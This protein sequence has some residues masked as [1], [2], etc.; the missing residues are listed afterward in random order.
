MTA[1]Q[2]GGRL[3]RLA[4]RPAPD[5]VDGPDVEERCEMCA[6]PL[7]PE[8][9]HLL[10]V[11]HQL[12]VCVCRA[13]ALLFD[14]RESG[15]GHYRRV[16]DRRVRLPELRLDDVQWAGFGIPVDIA[17]FVRSSASKRVVG[18]YPSPLGTMR[19][20]LD[21]ESWD[22]LEAD[23]PVLR[24]MEEDVEALL[25]NR[26]RG[27]RDHWLLPVTDCYRLVAAIRTHWKGIS[28]GHEVWEALSGFFG[29]LPWGPGTSVME[30]HE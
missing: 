1:L 21:L 30:E 2:P 5:P 8:H 16:P 24:E 13:C 22:A 26:L 18:L 7:A 23:N 9:D 12:P 25:V 11:H 4:R 14:R 27:A 10:D 17:F 6:E 3:S 15:G 28:G 29:S 20:A 19:S